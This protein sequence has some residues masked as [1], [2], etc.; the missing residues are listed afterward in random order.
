MLYALMLEPVVEAQPLA[1]P[2]QAVEPEPLTISIPVQEPDSK[3]LYALIFELYSYIVLAKSIT[4]YS[5]VRSVPP[6]AW[7]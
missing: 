7:W 1:E 6:L 4:P 5:P 2:E 3:M